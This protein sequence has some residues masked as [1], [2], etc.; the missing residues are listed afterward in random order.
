MFLIYCRLILLFII[1]FSVILPIPSYE[2]DN[3]RTNLYVQQKKCPCIVSGHFSRCPNTAMFG[4]FF[5]RKSVQTCPCTDTCMAKPMVEN[6]GPQY[7]DNQRELESAEKSGMNC[8][9][10]RSWCLESKK[11]ARENWKFMIFERALYYGAHCRNLK[12]TQK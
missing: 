3:A 1:P 6:W 8:F 5:S 7:Q 9:Y 2:T 11:L 10:L 4:H 12:I